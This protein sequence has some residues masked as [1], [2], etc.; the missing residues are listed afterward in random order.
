MKTK[1]A[2]S[3]IEKARFD[4]YSEKPLEFYKTKR[5]DFVFNSYRRS[6]VNEIKFYLID[7]DDV[8]PITALEDFIHMCDTFACK[9]T[10]SDANFMFS[11][12]C[13]V[14]TDMLD[15][16]IGHVYNKEVSK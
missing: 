16:L 15:I 1:K 4:Y 12:Y 3:L 14:A 9:T 6:A 7:H 13:D 8:H 2:L 10:N 11:V 5:V